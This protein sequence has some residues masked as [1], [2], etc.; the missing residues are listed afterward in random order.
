MDNIQ[1]I[2]EYIKAGETNKRRL[3]VE[4]E[5]FVCNENYEPAGAELIHDFLCKMERGGGVLSENTLVRDEY[6]LTLEPGYQVEI[7]IVPCEKISEIDR[8]YKGFRSEADAILKESGYF[9]LECSMQP[10]AYSGSMSAG[11]FPFSDKDR[12]V[13]MDKYFEESGMLGKYMMRTTASTQI[14]VDYSCEK[15]CMHKLRMLEILSPVFSLITQTRPTVGRSYKWNKNLV[16][17]QVWSDVDSDRC[18]YFPKS[19]SKKYSYKEYAEYVYSRPLIIY[20]D[21]DGRSI[22]AGEKSAS[23]VLGNEEL[24]F[25][26]HLLSMLFPT[27]RLKNYIEIRCADSM[28]RERMLGY[29]ALIKG[30]VYSERSMIHLE[31]IFESVTSES[32]IRAAERIISERGYSSVIYGLNVTELISC[33][34]SLARAALDDEE[35]KYLNALVPLKCAELEY[36]KNIR[37]NPEEYEKSAAVAKNYIMSSSAKYHN[38]VV[39]TMYVPKIFTKKDIKLF[40]DS[41][42]MLYKIFEKVIKRYEND[43]EYRAL[44]GFDKRLEKLI[45]RPR[46]YSCSIP[47]SRIDIFYDEDLEDFSFCEFNTDGTSAMNE[48]RELNIAL[49]KTK[50]YHEFSKRYSPHSFELFD[51]WVDEVLKIYGEYAEKFGRGKTPNVVITDFMES[52][53]ENEFNIF[54]ERFEARG[55]KCEVC[56]IRQLRFDGEKCTTPDGMTVDA[57]YRRAVTS[58]IMTHYDEVQPFI[59]AAE[60]NAFCLIG[61]FRTQIVHNKILYKILHMDQTLDMLTE[62]ERG[63]VERHV[64][65]TVTL[66]DDFLKKNPS[67]LSDKDS[68]II[69]PE[70]LYGS[71]GVHA[72]VECN[73]EQWSECINECK[74]KGYILQK[75]CTPHELYNIDLTGEKKWCVVSNLTGMFVYNGKFC[76]IYSRISYDKMISTQYNEMSLPTI[77]I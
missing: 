31:K 69:K 40:S 41:I 67:V 8:I 74:N 56:E 36:I 4:I 18:G 16:R 66:D 45:L 6:T 57:V 27:V 43:S 46:G 29:A 62:L 2:T 39:R 14:S 34:F 1:V 10:K 72:G 26:E 38:R 54:K 7:S 24:Y 44:F 28:D 19:A 13:F 35:A 9:L 3:G 5:H 30:L 59:S 64:P 12:Y 65:Y 42:E 60:N 77:Y 58:D 11:E 75:F 22:Y 73:V 17:A 48:D 61:D 23:Y 21:R 25:T 49:K 70:D 51:S 68:W 71:M 37:E 55:I 15:D 53:T 63:F 20:Y 33:L 47:I 52:A 32:E 76:G 50:A